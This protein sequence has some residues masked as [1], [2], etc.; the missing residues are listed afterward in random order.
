[1]SDQEA[2]SGSPSDGQVPD[3]RYVLRLY[4]T[5]MTPRSVAAIENIR[6][7]CEEHL[8]GRYE[9]EIVDIYQHPEASKEAQ[10]LAAPTMI[11]QLP[12]PLRRFVGDMSNEEKILVGLDLRTK[13]V[14]PQ[15]E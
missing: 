8:Q 4:V 13:E 5:G 14:W 1:M 2:S 6:R 15:N 3:E 9:L 11:K 10:L 7:I 12:L